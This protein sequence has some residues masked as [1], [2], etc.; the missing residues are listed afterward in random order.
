MSGVFSSLEDNSLQ[1]MEPCTLFRYVSFETFVGMVQA[2]ALTF[3]LPS[4]WDDPKERTPFFRYLNEKKSWLEAALY[5]ATYKKVYAQSWSQVAESDAMWRIYSYGNKALRI[6]AQSEKIAKL[7]GVE[8]VK[9][10]YSDEDN[11]LNGDSY[12]AFLQSLAYKRTAFSH[13]KEVRLIRCYKYIDENDALNHVKALLCLQD[14]PNRWK[15][16][17]SM[18]PDKS[19][20]EKVEKILDI[21]NLGKNSKQT[22]EISYRHIPDFIDSV[23]VHPLAPMW[24]V[25]IVEE[26]CRRN[27]ISFEGKSKLYL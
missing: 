27:H 18:F 10:I 8:M 25:D 14:D 12:D 23:M 5:L 16:I 9:V 17:E 3:V 13:E 15:L 11:D 24:Y 21:L 26:F 2:E 20:E 6:K 1:K 19:M 22:K 7:D 4:A